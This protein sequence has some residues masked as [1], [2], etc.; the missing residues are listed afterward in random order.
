[1]VGGVLPVLLVVAQAPPALLMKF[2]EVD[3]LRE[4]ASVKAQ[5]A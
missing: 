4:A 1:M 3:D 2:D 5:I